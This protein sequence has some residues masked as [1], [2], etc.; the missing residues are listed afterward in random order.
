LIIKR[1]KAENRRAVGKKIQ[2][3]TI[4]KGVIPM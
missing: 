4:H 2:V 3:G 1:K